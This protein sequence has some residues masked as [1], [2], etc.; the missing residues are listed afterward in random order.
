MFKKLFKRKEKNNI[1]PEKPS[2][3]ET[4][5]IDL[6]EESK[7]KKSRFSKKQKILIA[8][9]SICLALI[10]AVGAF[11]FSL[12][13]VKKDYE[14]VAS[15]SNMPEPVQIETTGGVTKSIDDYDITIDFK[16][17]YT[18]VG[19]VVETYYYFPY[20]MINKLSRFDFGMAWGAMSDDTYEDYI[21]YKNNG[22]R[23]LTYKYK[24]SL[25]DILGSKEAVVNSISNNHMIHANNRV[26]KLLRNV[27]VGDHIKI[28]GYLSYVSYKSDHS[29]GDWNSSLSRTD[30]GDG[31]CEIIYVT[32]I[33]WLKSK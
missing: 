8:V 30:H 22:N 3:N 21:S 13:Y 19:K 9:T 7:T 20:K 10:I 18:L 5:L 26:L 6:I 29:Y 27:R 31:A 24:N 2:Q 12:F 28:E 33:T 16:A 15:F 17:S 4:S 1:E 25:V 14:T 32:N 23:F 11:A